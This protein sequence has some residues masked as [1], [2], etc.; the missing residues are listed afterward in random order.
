MSE[1]CKQTKSNGEQCKARAVKNGLCVLH[2]N[3][4]L[5]SKLGRRSGQVRRHVDRKK[6]APEI[7]GGI[8]TGRARSTTR[9]PH[10]TRLRWRDWKL[11]RR[12]QNC[13]R[14][15]IRG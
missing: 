5:A 3:P 2:A 6:S 11:P 8:F 1:R 10:R 4:E 15:C 12:G 14:G 13:I 9:A 7:T